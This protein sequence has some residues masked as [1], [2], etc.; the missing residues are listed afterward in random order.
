MNGAAAVAE[1]SISAPRTTITKMIGSNHHFLLFR[2]RC[3]NSSAS[4]GREWVLVA[5]SNCVIARSPVDCSR[6]PEV[7]IHIACAGFGDP[8]RI[9]L[10]PPQAQHVAALHP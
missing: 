6:L 3:H 1:N 4:P 7:L 8:V 2:I 5:S 9:L 10:T